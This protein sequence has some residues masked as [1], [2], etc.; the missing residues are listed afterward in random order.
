MKS[1]SRDAIQQ[2][3]YVMTYTILHHNSCVGSASKFLWAC[4]RFWYKDNSNKKRPYSAKI[5]VIK[6]PKQVNYTEVG[7]ELYWNIMIVLYIQANVFSIVKNLPEILAEYLLWY[8][9][10]VSKTYAH[11]KLKFGEI[12]IFYHFFDDVIYLYPTT[13]VFLIA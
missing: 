3:H 1:T 5:L 8:R 9:Y 2:R 12:K 4:C 6:A 10:T 11:Q 13:M 7:I